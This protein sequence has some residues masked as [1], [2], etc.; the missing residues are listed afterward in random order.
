MGHLTLLTSLS[1][2]CGD[3]IQHCI[4]LPG[5]LSSLVELRQLTL[6]QVDLGRLPA[7][8]RGDHHD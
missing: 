3:D 5:A 1:V 4:G 7:F 2:T 6:E 8:V